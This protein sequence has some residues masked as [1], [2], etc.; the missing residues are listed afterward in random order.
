MA[1]EAR[2]AEVAVIGA[3]PHGLSVAAHLRR[4]GVEAQV[5]GHPMTFWRTMP[6]GMYLRSNWSATNIAA[7]T[8]KLSLDAYKAETGDEF[9]SPV[10]LANF[11]AYGSWFQQRAVPDVRRRIVERLDR[12][13]GGFAL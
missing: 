8:G 12:D 5:F 6:E 4:A 10:P 3:G 7:P 2:D 9:G 11:I 1:P 13:P